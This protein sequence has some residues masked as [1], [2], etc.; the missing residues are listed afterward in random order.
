MEIR[1]RS[2]RGVT[3]R[4]AVVLE[5]APKKA[6]AS[7]L[8]RMCESEDVLPLREP[9]D[10]QKDGAVRRPAQR[11]SGFVGVTGGEALEV[12]TAVDDLCLAR[13]GGH[14]QHELIA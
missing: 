4:L 5:V 9:A 11:A 6:F 13:R 14:S 12:D 1:R 2:L 3:D 10:T 7:A 8:E